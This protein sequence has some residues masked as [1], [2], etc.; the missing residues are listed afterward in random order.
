MSGGPEIRVL[1]GR[2]TPDELAVV[3]TVLLT[4][5]RGRREGPSA[6][7][8]ADAPASA[9]ASVPAPWATHPYPDWQPLPGR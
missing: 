5:L 6:P 3:T 8:R 4:V 7:G 2:P 1:H 9:P